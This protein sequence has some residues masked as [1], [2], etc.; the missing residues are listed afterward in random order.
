MSEID[1]Q[2][3]HSTAVGAH[4]RYTDTFRADEAFKVHSEVDLEA[5][6]S[7]P[8]LHD[9]RKYHRRLVS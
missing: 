7:Y 8:K 5:Y 6:R 4:H 9:E 2:A 1:Q 3:D